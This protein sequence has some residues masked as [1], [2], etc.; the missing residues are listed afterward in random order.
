M[1]ERLLQVASVLLDG[2]KTR[3]EIA[4]AMFRDG[5][6]SNE[7]SD[8]H[9]QTLLKNHSEARDAMPALFACKFLS[10][11]GTGKPHSKRNPAIWSLTA[12]GRK[13]VEKLVTN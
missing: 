2:P 1:R 6:I 10:G 3:R 11:T 7:R 12:K 5:L 13:I 9:T 4:E 8:S